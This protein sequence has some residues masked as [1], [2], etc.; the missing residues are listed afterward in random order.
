[1]QEVEKR[2]FQWETFNVL[3]GAATCRPGG[4]GKAEVLV[5]V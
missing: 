1:M 2:E 5:I 4:Q 3:S